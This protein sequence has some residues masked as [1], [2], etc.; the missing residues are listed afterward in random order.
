M[1]GLINKTSREKRKSC[2]A[3]LA[4]L[5]LGMS[6]GVSFKLYHRGCL[7]GPDYVM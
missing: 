6:D 5:A 1:N 4:N 2:R 7:D 3:G